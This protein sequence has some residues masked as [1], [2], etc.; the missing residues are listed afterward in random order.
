M[1]G[2]QIVIPNQPAGPDDPPGTSQTI[3]IG[4]DPRT[5]SPAP[6]AP[7]PDPFEFVVLNSNI[8]LPANSPIIVQLTSPLGITI[9][10]G[11][12]GFAPDEAVSGF[13]SEG[14]A[15]N[16]FIYR[17]PG[18]Q[19]DFPGTWEFDAFLPNGIEV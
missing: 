19:L 18:F 5:P 1:P 15:G 8:P 12:L 17:F 2:Q 4:P 10:S 9:T 13:G 3:F 11:S 16:Y 14:N 6:G 7:P